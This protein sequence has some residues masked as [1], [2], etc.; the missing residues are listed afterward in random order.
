MRQ[1]WCWNGVRNWDLLRVEHDWGWKRFME[2]SKVLEGFTAEDTLM[3]KAQVQ[4]IRCGAA[5]RPMRRSGEAAARV[6]QQR[7]QYLQPLRGGAPSGAAGAAFPRPGLSP[8]AVKTAQP[9]HFPAAVH[10]V[11]SHPRSCAFDQ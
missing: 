10:A 8:Q 2:I 1:W 9:G 3:I 11:P 6:R 4:V 5:R 7:G